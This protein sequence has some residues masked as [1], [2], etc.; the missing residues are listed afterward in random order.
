[1]MD[2]LL[3]RS[4]E[5]F[6]ASDSSSN[7]NKQ[8]RERRKMMEAK[9]KEMEQE[10]RNRGNLELSEKIAGARGARSEELTKLQEEEKAIANQRMFLGAAKNMIEEQ[11]FDD[12]LK[13]AEREAM[14]RQLRAKQV[15]AYVYVFIYL[16]RSR[17]SF[18]ILVHL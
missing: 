12:Q 10:R 1:M 7:M 11:H 8:S 6:A 13:G 2:V 4:E 14:E 9:A 16:L 15:I 5:S 17:V 3:L 18:H